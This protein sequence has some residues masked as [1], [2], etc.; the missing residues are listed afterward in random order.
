MKKA[1]LSFSLLCCIFTAEANIVINTTRVIYLADKKET[2]VQLV[3]TS[4]QPALVQSW[5][6]DGDTASTPETS[7]VPFLL[8]PPVVK[9]EGRN[10]QQLRIKYLQGNLPADRESLFYLNVLDI[11]PVPDNVDG[12]N[13][14]QVAI[15][16]RIK[17]FF[18]PAG[19]SVALKDVPK[20]IKLSTKNART[21]TLEN[22]TP[23]HLNVI[24]L[25]GDKTKTN[26]LQEGIV[27]LPFATTD[28]KTPSGI[29]QN[30]TY[31]ITMI[32]DFGAQSQF[33]ITLHQ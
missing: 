13:M 26:I 25:Q 14:M 28:I 10:G 33:A 30:E 22:P 21:F 18:R 20:S 15:K 12:K 5:I 31:N 1:L 3:N 17:L 11:P 7:K 24:G 29:R 8:T 19:L 2:T 32:D 6:D 16:S 9:V 23:Y 27:V 4:E